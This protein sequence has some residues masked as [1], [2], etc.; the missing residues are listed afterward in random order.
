MCLP[1][2]ES[3]AEAA[4]SLARASIPRSK[5]CICAAVVAQI[6]CQRQL[7]VAVLAN[8]L[9]IVRVQFRFFFFVSD[10]LSH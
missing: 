3:R 10:T 7:A 6:C 9:F 1:L 4:E 8:W 5:R 2:A